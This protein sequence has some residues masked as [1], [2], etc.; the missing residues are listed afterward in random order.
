MRAFC[1]SFLSPL[2]IHHTPTEQLLLRNHVNDLRQVRH[3]L[4]V[5]L[6]QMLC[7]S[8]PHWWCRLGLRSRFSS[9]SGNGIRYLRRFKAFRHWLCATRR[10]TRLFTYVG[11]RQPNDLV[12]CVCVHGARRNGNDDNEVGHR[13]CCCADTPRSRHCC[14]SCNN[15]RNCARAGVLWNRYRQHRNANNGSPTDADCRIR[16]VPR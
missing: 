12:R 2:A 10:A 8:W 14:R 6:T 11:C 13:C 7:G 9:Q 1:G 4:K 16:S 3:K 15:Q 5:P